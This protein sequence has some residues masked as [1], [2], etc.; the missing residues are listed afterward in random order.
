MST[1]SPTPPP[2][3]PMS[4]STGGSTSSSDG[5]YPPPQHPSS[6]AFP[7]S[8]PAVMA[9]AL[10]STGSV[11]EFHLAAAAA[12]AAGDPKPPG[13]QT[14]PGPQELHGPPSGGH[15]DWVRRFRHVQPTAASDRGAVHVPQPELPL[16]PGSLLLHHIGI[17]GKDRSPD[18][19]SDSFASSDA[20]ESSPLL[21]LLCSLPSTPLL[22]SPSSLVLRWV[23]RC[24][25]RTVRCRSPGTPTLHA[26]LSPCHPIH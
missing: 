1:H 19:S 7:M 5:C 10:P 23:L 21:P 13:V 18:P 24:A 26:E 8:A 11:F 4:G 9:E 12:A 22:L 6:S 25:R 16:P 2:L 20:G 17:A 15:W 3:P 14:V